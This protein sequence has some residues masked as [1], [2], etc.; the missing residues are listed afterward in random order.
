MIRDGRH[1]ILLRPQIAN[2]LAKEICG[3]AR[4]VL[5][6]EMALMPTGRVRLAMPPALLPDRPEP[7][8]DALAAPARKVD[9][10]LLDRRCVT[11]AAYQRF[12]NAGGYDRDRWWDEAALPALFG[13][14][15]RTGQPAPRF[16]K[17]GRHPPEEAR[18]PVVGVSW[19]EAAAYARFVG[20][21]LPSDGEWVR[22]AAWPIVTDDG[23]LSERR[24]PWGNEFSARRANTGVYGAGQLADVDAFP[25]G[26]GVG[27]VRQLCGNAWEW[28]A[29]R[30]G[31][32]PSESSNYEL[33]GRW[34]S[35]RGGAFDTYFENQVTCQFQSGDSPLARR[36]NVS[37]R[38]ALSLCD[39]QNQP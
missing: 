26:E 15:D 39:V 20:K 12:V 2:T 10:F 11:N 14:V 1:A 25:A 28:T 35:L 16:W 23:Y 17:N 7:E 19:F 5:D 3:E 4:R 37:F 18:L 38:C 27:G 34:M 32:F 24:F 33:I 8:S 29:G 30:F 13:F 9:A 22:A 31:R 36:H 21:R 6:A